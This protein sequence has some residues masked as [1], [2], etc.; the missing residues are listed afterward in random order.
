MNTLDGKQM[1]ENLQLAPGQIVT[2]TN[3]SLPKGIY[4]KIRPQ[5]K[6]FIELSD[7]RAV[8]E[9]TLRNFSCLTKGDTIVINYNNTSYLIDILEV[10]SARGKCEAISIVEAD[11]RVD[12]ERP[13]DMPPSPVDKGPPVEQPF[14]S[15]IIPKGPPSQ[16]QQ[17]Q[18][19]KQEK[20]GFKPFTGSGR[21]LD[22]KIIKATPVASTA[23]SATVASTSSSCTS[24]GN[25]STSQVSSSGAPMVPVF[26]KKRRKYGEPASG[27]TSA[28]S[29]SSSD[30]KDEKGFKPF[31]GT[32]RTLK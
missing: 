17:Q 2:I 16:Q 24:N 3:A 23:S 1:Q 12:F 25:G 21:R 28:T 6:A 27:S 30:K 7:P 18:I 32:G 26:G 10:E 14:V 11:V 20:P 5:Q 9:K 31:Q 8:L 19:Q 22:G 4:C 29:T 15:D 13:L